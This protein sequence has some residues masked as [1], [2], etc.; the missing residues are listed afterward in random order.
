MSIAEDLEKF[1]V[2]ALVATVGAAIREFTDAEP[3]AAQKAKAAAE[4][5]KQALDLM[6]AEELHKYLTDDD[7]A[8]ALATAR[9]LKAIKL[10]GQ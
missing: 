2:D 6:P 1:A 7:A 9:M 8:Q 4:L 3:D 5:A 10:Q